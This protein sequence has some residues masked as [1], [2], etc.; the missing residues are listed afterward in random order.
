VA[1][2]QGRAGDN[3]VYVQPF[4]ATGAKYQISKGLGHHP[5]WSP[6]G[7]EI[8]YLP[9]QEPPLV[10]SVNMHPSF[11]VGNAPVQLPRRSNE[12]GP[13]TIRNYDLMPD[14]RFVGVV[15]AGQPP[16]G[17][18]GAQRIQVVLNWLEELKQN[19]PTK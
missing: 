11:S 2:Q 6:S 1:Y 5:L 18:P 12:G 16:P 13:A 10:V 3:A 8:V 14:G 7:K 17:T 9:A 15:N 4:P 19:V